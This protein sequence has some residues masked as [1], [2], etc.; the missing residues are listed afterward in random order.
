MV[1]FGSVGNAR[2]AQQGAAID[3]SNGGTSATLCGGTKASCCQCGRIGNLRA[4]TNTLV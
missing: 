2:S 4:Q 3:S 1:F